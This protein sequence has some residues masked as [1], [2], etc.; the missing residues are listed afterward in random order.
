MTEPCTTNEAQSQDL[1]SVW[2]SGF[3]WTGVAAIVLSTM[4]GVLQAIA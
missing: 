2:R 1:P 3:L 4:L